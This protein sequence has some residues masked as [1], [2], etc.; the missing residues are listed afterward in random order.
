MNIQR[1]TITIKSL[2]VQGGEQLGHHNKRLPQ[3]ITT[4]NNK[5]EWK[6]TSNS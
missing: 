3:T 2:T 1:I 5:K 6:Q 4:K